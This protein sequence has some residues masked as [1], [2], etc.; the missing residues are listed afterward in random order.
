MKESRTPFQIRQGALLVLAMLCPR[1]R[2]DLLALHCGS[3]CN[4]VSSKDGVPTRFR[5]YFLASKVQ[6]LRQTQSQQGSSSISVFQRQD[7]IIKMTD[8]CDTY[9]R[10]LERIVIC[11]PAANNIPELMNRAGAGPYVANRLVCK[12]AITSVSVVSA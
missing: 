9:K 10:C 3:F 5:G 12:A 6:D 7:V 8:N 1:L 11:Y 4:Q 2:F